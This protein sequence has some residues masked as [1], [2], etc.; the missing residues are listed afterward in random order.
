MNEMYIVFYIKI[1]V[2]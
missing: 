1:F 2:N